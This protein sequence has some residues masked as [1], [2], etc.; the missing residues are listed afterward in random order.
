LKRAVKCRLLV[1]QNYRVAQPRL[2]HWFCIY[3]CGVLVLALLLLTKLT[4][5]N[6]KKLLYDKI[7]V[8]TELGVAIIELQDQRRSSP[9][10]IVPHLEC[11]L[12]RFRSLQE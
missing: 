3:E 5:K 10:G 11:L 6:S 9:K 1:A 7:Y 2:V 12:Y 8:G 4:I